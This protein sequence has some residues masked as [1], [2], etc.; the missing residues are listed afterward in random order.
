MEMMCR[1]VL[2]IVGLLSIGLVTADLGCLPAW[3][4]AE[5]V[6]GPWD[7]TT[8]SQQTTAKPLIIFKQE[9]EKLTGTYRG[10]M[11]EASLQG[12]L[13]GNK[14]QFSVRLKF[15][16]EDFPV[17]YTGTV[18]GSTMKGTVQFGD[19]SSGKWTARRRSGT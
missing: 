12:T 11:G 6:S 2:L 16:D 3:T 9:G 17:T 19:S 15:R 13:K 10:R 1:N 5:D 4:F 8:E 7:L 14:I 18:E